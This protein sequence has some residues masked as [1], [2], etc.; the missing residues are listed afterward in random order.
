[1]GTSG[2]SQKEKGPG[3]AIPGSIEECMEGRAAWS[4]SDPGITIGGSYRDKAASRG[5]AL[6]A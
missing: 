6:T 4:R 5:E 2:H 1:M 3:M